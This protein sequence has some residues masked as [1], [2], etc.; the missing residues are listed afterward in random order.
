MLE[1]KRK[2]DMEKTPDGRLSPWYK[3]SEWR[4]ECGKEYKTYDCPDNYSHDYYI[5]TA[6][7]RK[8]LKTEEL[9]LAFECN[10]KWVDNCDFLVEGRCDAPMECH[11]PHC[12]K[13]VKD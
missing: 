12:W 13:W 5:C 9:W 1:S 8:Y 4:C 3:G 2:K 10:G 6:C 7:G 11:F